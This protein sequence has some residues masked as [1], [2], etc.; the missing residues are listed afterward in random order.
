MGGVENSDEKDQSLNSARKRESG[1]EETVPQ[2][3]KSRCPKA[4]GINSTE[5][6]HADRDGERKAS[7]SSDER[8]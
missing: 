5:R 1:K 4:K 2:L 3:N 7:V 8:K 6:C